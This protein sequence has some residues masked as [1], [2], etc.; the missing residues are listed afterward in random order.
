MREGVRGSDVHCEQTTMKTLFIDLE[1]SPYVGFSWGKYEQDIIEFLQ[2]SKVI[3]MAWKW[4]GRSQIYCMA[5]PDYSGYKAGIFNLDDKKL[6]VDLHDLLNQ[7]DVVCAHNGKAFDVKVAKTRMLINGLTPTRPFRIVDTKLVARANF[8]FPSN[9][10]DDISRLSLQDRKKNT[11]GFQLWRDCMDGNERAWRKMK[12]YNKHDVRLL[13]EAYLLMRPWMD[14]HPN[15]NVY[16]ESKRNCPVC[17]GTHLTR[18]GWGF[19][20]TG[21]R[22]R[23]KC[24]TCGKWSSGQHQSL[25]TKGEQFIR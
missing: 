16:D 24:N 22:P 4:E 19:T 18:K 8:K 25:Q 7:A 17:G 12:A 2:E 21:K 3:S 13:E 14:N 23:Y 15:R 9:K 5:L 11:G 1:T 20:S 10:L 6:V